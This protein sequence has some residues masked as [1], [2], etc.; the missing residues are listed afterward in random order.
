MKNLRKTV[1]NLVL[2]IILIIVTFSI[3]FRNQDFNKIIGLIFNIDFKYFLLG[4]LA[5]SL[6]FVFESLNVKNVLNVLGTKVKLFSVIKYSLIEFF[7]SGITPAA[8][9]GQPM[10]IYFMHKDGISVSLS[11]VALLVELIT[12]QVITIILGF[13]GLFSNLSILPSGFIYLFIIGTSLNLIALFTMLIGLFS[14]RLAKKIVNLFI[15]ILKLFNYSKV[16]EKKESIYK[17]LDSYNESAKIVKKH[18]YI[19]VK[20]FF[21]VLMQVFVY[22]SIPYFVCLSFGIHDLSIIRIILM[23]ALLFSS[24]SSIPMPGTVGISEGAFLSIYNRIFGPN[25]VGSATLLNRF[26]NFY[27]FILLGLIITVI[28]SL[29]NRKKIIKK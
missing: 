3:L 24:V 7:F 10:E 17:T 29:K 28:K 18:K 4:I 6:Y 14:K 13:V 12:F 20:S 25:L 11:T 5:M 21:I 15:R 2:F 9:G 1:K 16:E 27:F 22:L 8:S 23:Q 26:I 19:F